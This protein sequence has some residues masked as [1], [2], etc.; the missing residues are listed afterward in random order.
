VGVDPASDFTPPRGRAADP[1]PDSAGERRMML[2][3]SDDGAHFTPSGQ[4][5][6]DRANV[7]DLLVDPDGT[8]RVYYIGHGIDEP[9]SD[10]RGPRAQPLERTVL[11]TS[12]DLGVTWRF[13]RLTFADLPQPREPSDP[14]VVRLADGTYRMYYTTSL[15][16]GHLGIAYATSPDGLT[17]T[18]GAT[19]LAGVGGLDVVDSTTLW[20]G[21]TWH[22]WV[23]Q[24]RIPGQFH[25]TS[26]DGL[27]F[28]AASPPELRLP[29]DRY[30]A[31]DPVASDARVHL[32]AFNLQTHTLRTFASTDLAA[33]TAEDVALEGDD[34]ATDG[35]RFLQDAVVAP[36][37][38]G[39]TLMVYV[40]GLPESPAR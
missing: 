13:R 33:W 23:G 8:L 10:A 34:L 29:L 38:D 4:I 25:A 17:F 1:P 6:S 32:L 20:F 15:A 11:A 5:L 14:D 40:S 9:S 2:A 39:R 7:P 3:F 19:A 21:G 12:A 27:T 37:T 28:T 22:M 30:Y 16:G 18:Y 26:S 24:E 36:L 31:C 35:T